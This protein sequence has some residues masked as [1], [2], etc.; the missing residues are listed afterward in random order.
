MSTAVVEKPVETEVKDVLAE[1]KE[2]I[3]KALPERRNEIRRVIY[4]WDN[5][6][7]VNFH[8]QETFFIGD[9][10]FVSI[11]GDLVSASKEVPPK[12]RED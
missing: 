4:L 6:Y 2:L 11:K 7:R 12:K 3:N 9:S 10:Y 1:Q 5:H 8:L